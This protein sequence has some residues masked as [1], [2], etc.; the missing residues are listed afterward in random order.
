MGVERRY[1][2]GLGETRFVHFPHFRDAVTGAKHRRSEHG[3][4]KS[5]ALGKR[6][7]STQTHMIIS[8]TVEIQL[9]VHFIGVKFGYKIGHFAQCSVKILVSKLNCFFFFL[10][11]NGFFILTYHPIKYYFFGVKRLYIFNQFF[12]F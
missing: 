2:R 9:Q 12:L 3:D 6:V 5:S 8:C 10:Q 4:P 11:M 1:N 7:V